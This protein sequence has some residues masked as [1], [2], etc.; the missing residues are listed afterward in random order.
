MRKVWKTPVLE[1]L[2]V[3]MTMA[4]INGSRYDGNYSEDEQI[5]IDPETGQHMD[6]KS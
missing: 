5:P 1:V 2:D 6:S 4:S 3:K